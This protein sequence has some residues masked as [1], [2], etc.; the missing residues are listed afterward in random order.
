MKI[1]SLAALSLCVSLSARVA[2]GEVT[3][4][5][6]T[7][8]PV[9]GLE[10]FT[11]KAVMASA[12]ETS[13]VAFLAT[14]VEVGPDIPRHFLVVV[15][16]E[17]ANVI[18]EEGAVLPG[19]EEL[20]PVSLLGKGTN[21]GSSLDIDRGQVSFL[22]A[23][24]SARDFPSAVHVWNPDG[25]WTTRGRP[26]DVFADSGTVDQI[27]TAKVYGGT[28]VFLG[29]EG[30]KFWF[31][32]SGIYQL[33]ERRTLLKLG[34]TLPDTDL[35]VEKLDGRVGLD[36]DYDGRR[37]LC[38]LQ[39]GDRKGDGGFPEGTGEWLI[40]DE[41]DGLRLE[42]VRT[43][44]ENGFLPTLVA[45]YHM[46]EGPRLFGDALLWPISSVAAGERGIALG[47]RNSENTKWT[48]DVMITAGAEDPVRGASYT[49]TDVGTPAVG[50]GA[51]FVFAGSAK[52][53]GMADEPTIYGN[54]GGVWQVLVDQ[55]MV[56]DEGV[57]IAFTVGQNAWDGRTLVFTAY[58]DDGSH[59]L[60]S[61]SAAPGSMNYDE[62]VLLLFPEATESNGVLDELAD[63]DGDG[64]NNFIEFCI[65]TDGSVADNEM[66]MTV[67]DSGARELSFTRRKALAGA[68]EIVPQVLIDGQWLEGDNVLEEVSVEALGDGVRDRVV[69]RI[70]AG[71]VSGEGRVVLARLRLRTRSE[72][73]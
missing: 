10:M 26:G 5:A 56:E 48:F 73:S 32:V 36:F 44:D 64:K 13:R 31:P 15:S 14:P 24:P 42:A 39:T 12:V 3:R 8:E 46:V 41:L 40:Y 2:W 27:T 63:P 21:L 37:V 49:V 59:G 61:V 38:S 43:V 57:A 34:D 30:R 6:K 33:P 65:G 29:K 23:H 54:F 71:V 50:P 62:W 72:E 9:P 20:G 1:L 51:T 16:G 35:R 68:Y 53:L 25:S 11:V 55:E 22:A 67:K 70:R 66:P 52:Q 17:T 69:V 58:F 4:I 18:V 47:A 7:G 19:S 45:G 60:Y 28:S